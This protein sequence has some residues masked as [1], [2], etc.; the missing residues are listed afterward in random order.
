MAKAVKRV[1]ARRKSL[2]RGKAGSKSASKKIAKRAAPKKV[3]AKRTTNSVRKAAA[4]RA[5]PKKARAKRTTNTVRKAVAKRATPKKVR[6]KSH[7]AVSS[8]TK[9]P[10]GKKRP[11]KTASRKP[12]KNLADLQLEATTIEVIKE[13]THGVVVATDYVLSQSPGGEPESGE[14]GDPEKTE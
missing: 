14:R 6:A 11:T 5:T 9:S 7:R 8:A 12:S 4:K 1:P 2:K 3:K 13:P 10:P